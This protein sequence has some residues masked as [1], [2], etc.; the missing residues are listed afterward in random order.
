MRSVFDDTVSLISEVYGD[1]AFCR[2]AK[3]GSRQTKEI[4]LG[5]YD[6]LMLTLTL[7]KYQQMKQVSCRNCGYCNMHVFNENFL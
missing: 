7:P 6:P 3:D 1:K 5:L 4:A 2:Q